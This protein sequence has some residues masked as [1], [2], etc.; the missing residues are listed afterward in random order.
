MKD[1]DQKRE[2][3]FDSKVIHAGEGPDPIYGSVAPPI[4]QTSTFAFENADQGAARFKGEEKGYIYTRLGNPTIARLEEKVAVLEGGV[5]ALATA[6]GMAAVNTLYFS[7]LSSGDHVVATS[8]L[9]GPARTILEREWARFGVESTWVDTGDIDAVESALK[10]N[11]KLLYIETPANPTI[12]LTDIRACAELARG[13]GIT[14]A[15]DNTFATPVLQN[16]LSLGADIVLHSVTKFIN[17]HTDV[18]GGIIVFKDAELLGKVTKLLH[19]LGSTMDPGQ[20]WLVLRGAKTLKMRVEKSQ[21]NAK[22]IARMLEDHEAVEWVKY[23]GL[24]SHPQF[25][26]AKRQ[27]KGP[28]S[29]MS[30]ELKGGLEAGKKLMNS[31]RVCTLAVSLGGIETLIQHPASM[32]HAVMGPEARAQAGISDGLIRLSVGCEDVNDLLEDL[33]QALNKTI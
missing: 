9:Y 28:G 10:P 32:T 5:G 4:Y 30:F 17:G 19:M 6:T 18:V 24:E 26:L 13:R 22:Q 14:V 29:L 7:V 15:V 33:D 16:P 31:V 25:E 3:R 2:L 27:M 8:S 23:P 1:P 20:A 21:D 11:T 12:R